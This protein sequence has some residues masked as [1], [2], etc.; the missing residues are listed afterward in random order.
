[1]VEK[2]E[3]ILNDQDQLSLIMETAKALGLSSPEGSISVLPQELTSQL[4]ASLQQFQ[5]NDQK[6]QALFRALLPYL[7][8]GK[9]RRLERAMQ[10]AKIS[11]VAEAT[12]LGR[13]QQSMENDH[14]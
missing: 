3:Q 2:L 1:M 14:V 13:I 4:G 10:V 7:R 5:A 9:Q 8:P 6:Y 12:L 11:Y